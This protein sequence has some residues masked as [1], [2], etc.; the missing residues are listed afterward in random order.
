VDL[1]APAVRDLAALVVPAD[2]VAQ[3]GPVNPADQAVGMAATGQEVTSPVVLAGTIRVA[4]EATGLGVLAARVDQGSLV[5]PGDR[6]VRASRVVLAGTIRAHPAVTIPAGRGRMVQVLRA[7]GLR[8]RAAQA[9]NPGRA[10][11]DLTPTVLDRAHRIRTPG[12]PDLTP[13]HPDRTCP[14]GPMRP[15]DRRWVATAR[16]VAMPQEA[17]ARPADRTLRLGATRRAAATPPAE[18][19]DLTP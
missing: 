2:R 16:A 13:A 15:A 1:A 9:L 18:V 17:Q 14:A 10:R 12:V 6:V 5:G 11:L 4:P 3:V 8:G 7:Q 19:T